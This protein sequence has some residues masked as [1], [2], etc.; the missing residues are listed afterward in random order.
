M[1]WNTQ[2][3]DRIRK[4]GGGDYLSQVGH[5]EQGRPISNEQFIELFNQITDLLTLAPGDTLLDL[6]CGNGVFTQKLAKRCQTAVGADLSEDLINIA[7]TDHAAPNLTY[8]ACD[9]RHID[10]L[11]LPAEPKFSK[12]LMYA[13]LQHFGRNDLRGLLLSLWPV[14]ETG[15][16][17]LFGFIPDADLAHQFYD[18]P[19]RRAERQ[20]RIE[21][22]TDPIG[23]WWKR[24]TV[25]QCAE[26][27]G[28]TCTFA[29]VP[30][31][32]HAARYRFHAIMKR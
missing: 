12:V 10:T 24:D 25:K 29:E 18:T 17:F 16:V 4:S 3:R 28:L 26:E 27:A 31:G 6:C 32:H 11:P 9:A 8:Y 19:E 13:A 23:E 15:T 5:T 20:R 2:Y 22:G 14:T 1:D 21:E 30:P 7:Q